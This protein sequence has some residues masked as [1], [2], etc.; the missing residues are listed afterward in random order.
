LVFSRR[1]ADDEGAAIL[2]MIRLYRRRTLGG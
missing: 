2:E 1:E